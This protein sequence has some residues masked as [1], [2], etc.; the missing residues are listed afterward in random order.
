MS[1]Q[2]H[3]YSATVRKADDVVMACSAGPFPNWSEISRYHTGVLAHQPQ[4]L[5]PEQSPYEHRVLLDLSA[6]AWMTDEEA[7]V[8][9]LL[10]DPVLHA[11]FELGRTHG[12]AGKHKLTR[13]HDDNRRVEL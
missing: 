6:T 5:C 10:H 1:N 4:R 3:Y 9:L 2:P 13:R 7:V 8:D 11:I 12:A